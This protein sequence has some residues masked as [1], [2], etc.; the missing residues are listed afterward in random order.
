MCR[1]VDDK[2]LC[3]RSQS[4]VRQITFDFVVDRWWNLNHRAFLNSLVQLK[5]EVVRESN[6]IDVA[7]SPD[8]PGRSYPSRCD[9]R[10]LTESYH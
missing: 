7:H 5:L 8:S 3:A 4:A 1:C 6:R 9:F 2:A 10:P